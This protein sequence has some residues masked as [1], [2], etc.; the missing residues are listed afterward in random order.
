MI[1]ISFI[2]ESATSIARKMHSNEECNYSDFNLKVNMK[3]RL[4]AGFLVYIYSFA[5]F[6]HGGGL[7]QNGCHHESSTGSYHCHNGG[8]GSDNA[9]N[10]SPGNVAL[11]TIA[12][13]L[14]VYWLAQSA[15]KVQLTTFDSTPAPDFYI[16]TFAKQR[17]F[18]MTLTYRY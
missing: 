14:G 11:L 9:S 12:V 1:D 16:N 3:N 15:K 7:D 17:A 8:S 13:T 18:G 10:L 2:N 4:L 6:A 5:C